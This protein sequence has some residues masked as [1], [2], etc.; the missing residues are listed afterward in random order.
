MPPLPTMSLRCQPEH[1]ALIRDIARNLRTR[2]ELAGALAALLS[3]AAPAALAPSVPADVLA[4]LE[5]VERWIA[6]RNTDALQSAVRPAVAETV[7]AQPA[8]AKVEKRNATATHDATRAGADDFPARLVLARKAKGWSTRKLATEA[9]VAQPTISHI[10]T[11]RKVGSDE[12][13]AKLATVLGIAH[14]NVV[15]NQ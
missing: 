8:P 12:T 2:P 3:E 4:R 9:G 1:Q 13:R 5:A 15:V 7:E 10:E 11:G 6:E 14:E